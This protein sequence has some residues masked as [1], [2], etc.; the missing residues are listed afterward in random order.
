MAHF[1]QLDENNIVTQVIVVGND[2]CTDAN[3]NE[4]ESIGVAFCQKLLGAETR[5]RDDLPNPTVHRSATRQRNDD[6]NSDRRCPTA[7]DR[8]GHASPSRHLDDARDDL[9][10]RDG[11]RRWLHGTELLQ[12][13]RCP[14]PLALDPTGLR[15]QPTDRS[16]DLPTRGLELGPL[17]GPRS[18]HHRDLLPTELP[19]SRDPPNELDAPDPEHPSTSHL[20]PYADRVPATTSPRDGPKDADRSASAASPRDHDPNA[21]RNRPTTNSR[22]DHP[23]RK[24]SRRSASPRPGPKN[25]RGPR[26]GDGP[27]D[28]LQ[29]A[30]QTGRQGES[31]I[32]HR[33]GRPTRYGP[34]G[35]LQRRGRRR[36]DPCP[37]NPNGTRGPKGHG[38]PT[39]H[40]NRSRHRNPL[41]PSDRH[42]TYP[43]RYLR[44]RDLDPVA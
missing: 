44:K 20:D 13:R 36:R 43:D 23:L 6:A 9:P 15:R 1:A 25:S 17:F 21:K 39:G 29:T 8:D 37:D 24:P 40:Q 38:P 3:G 14:I 19:A 28:R 42:P 18:D 5:H 11:R 2:D 30:D 27:A 32:H 12:A 4:V 33:T 22:D 34:K 16:A 41:S 31:R 7:R 10:T 26:K 35:S